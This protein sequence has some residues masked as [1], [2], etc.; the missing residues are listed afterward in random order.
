MKDHSKTEQGDRE[1]GNTLTA[2]LQG[3][4]E[5]LFALALSAKVAVLLALSAN[6]QDD[7]D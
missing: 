3:V 6:Q 5:M 7:Q 2:L 1:N 4:A